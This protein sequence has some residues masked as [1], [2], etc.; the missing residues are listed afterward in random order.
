[1]EFSLQIWYDYSID[2]VLPVK[3]GK[4]DENIT[5]KDGVKMKM[6]FVKNFPGMGEC[7]AY[8][9]CP[10]CAKKH[11]PEAAALLDKVDEKRFPGKAGPTV[12][13][14]LVHGDKLVTVVIIGFGD[15]IDENSFAKA[16]AKGVKEAKKAKP[17]TIGVITGGPLAGKA[18]ESI[19]LADNVYETHKT[20]KADKVDYIIYGVE[21]DEVKEG[22]VLGNAVCLTRALVNEPS[23]VMTP[24]Q[25]A[26]EALLA[27]ADSGFKVNVYDL[28]EIEKLGMKA[29][30]EVARGSDREPKLIAMSYMGDPDSEEILGLVGK[31]LC[32]DSGGYSLK[33]SSGMETMHTDMGGAGA[34]IGAMSAIAKMKLKVNVTAVVAAC[35]NILSAHAYHPGD[36]IGS[37]AGI[38]I[39][40]NNTDAEG[41]ITLADAVTYAA[42]KQNA[43]RIIDAATLTGAAVAAFGSSFTP[44]VSDSDELWAA[45]EKA[46]VPAGEKVWRMPMDDELFEGL[47]SDIAD[48]KNSG[49]RG[50]TITGGMF[51]QKFA[52]GRPW[53][54]LDIAGTSYTKG[55]DFCQ[56]GA[57]GVAVRLL[58]HVAK[59]SVK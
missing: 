19:I 52:Q 22:I 49:G 59:D 40:V 17:A 48:V 47:K 31:G 36:V 11:I 42:V 29:F 4:R 5:K 44:V 25:L 45:L 41:R 18:V 26:T 14:N 23:N 50:G 6:T 38:T 1:M 28:P 12:A 7:D 10:G 54:H 51:I 27:G 9:L 58:Y 46:S 34:V 32:Y 57:T 20:E 2:P 8:V 16:Y 30:L 55:N 37:M 39:E 24:A 56:F 15:K 33:P 13:L 43:T 35:E 3:S 21:E 53:A